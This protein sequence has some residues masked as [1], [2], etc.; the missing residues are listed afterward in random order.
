MTANPSS[1]C[2]WYVLYTQTGRELL[3]ASLLETQV[4]VTVFLPEVRQPWQGRMALRPLFPRYLFVQ[5]DL[6]Q[7]AASAIAATPGV[8]RLVAWNGHPTPVADMTIGALRQE[9][10]RLNA[11][12]G[13]LPTTLR[14][15]DRVRLRQ[16]PLAGLEGVFV[17][18]LAPGDRAAILLRFLNQERSVTVDLAG[19]EAIAASAA[20]PPRQRSSRGRGRVIHYG[21][22]ERCAQSSEQN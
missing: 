6:T 3:V 14:P 15:G 7:V 17:Q 12:G 18:A 20:H 22:G 9:C 5:A 10:E 1:V 21:I 4:P 11:A 13:L 16:G 19:V 2:P 8:T